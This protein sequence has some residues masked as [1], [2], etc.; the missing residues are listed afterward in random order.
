MC[1]QSVETIVEEAVTHSRTH[2]FLSSVSM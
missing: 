1:G 2:R